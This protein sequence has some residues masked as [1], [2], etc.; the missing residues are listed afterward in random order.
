MLV[1]ALMTILTAVAL[2]SVH[3]TPAMLRR[4]AT[5]ALIATAALVTNALSWSGVASGLS[6]HGGTLELT[7]VSM[8]CQ[9]LVALLGAV[10]LTLT[11]SKTTGVSTG[12]A[13]VATYPLFALFT[14]LG[15]STLVCAGDLVTLYVALELQSFSVYVMAAL[16]RDSE[17]ATH[18]GLLY[19]ML[20]GLSSCIILLGF[21][22]VYSQTGLTSLDGLYSL[23]HASSIDADASS[24]SW[25]MSLG[26]VAIG[27]GMLFK[28]TAAPF[29]HWGP[30]VYDGVPTLV[31]TWLSIMP[32]VA[33]LGLVLSLT[34][35]YAGSFSLT[36]VN[37]DVWTTL[38]LV[39]CVLSLVVGTVVGLAQTRIKR[40]LAYSTVSHMGFMLLALAV[41]TE[42]ATAAYCFYLVQYMGTSLL[43]FSTLLAMGYVRGRG[44]LGSISEL[45]NA[46][47]ASP[48]L[49]LCLAAT[50]FSMA[51]VPPLLGFFGKQAVLYAA[52]NAG[53]V[54]TSII[55]VV[56]SIISASYYLYVVRVAYF[57][58]SA[59]GP[60]PH[61]SS[62]ISSVHSYSLAVLSLGLLGFM[63]APDLVLDLSRLVALQVHTV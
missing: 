23:L 4:T 30:D 8:L 25:T 19:F 47:K 46:F 1:L 50:L 53:Y 24:Y 18:S 21:A 44:E 10:A 34:H 15:A 12:V 38:M 39:S 35:V 7:G 28:V 5:L 22:L 14:V 33:L 42:E 48:G 51:G 36:G 27:T 55:A 26:L 56:T 2:P 49:A 57:N 20:G 29:H 37:A 63:A 17:T 16:Q 3:A 13:N 61:T 45:V 31:T 9:A 62:A 40:L 11:P 54:F 43:G 6:L 59:M 58:D 32:K 52:I 41:S 60:T